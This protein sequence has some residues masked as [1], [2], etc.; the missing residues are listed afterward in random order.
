MFGVSRGA[1]S[2]AEITM[3]KP[4][5]RRGQC[6]Y[7]A[8]LVTML[9]AISV[10]ATSANAGTGDDFPSVD[11]LGVSDSEIRVGGVANV[12]QNPT[13]ISFGSAFDGVEAYFAYINQ[14]EGGV[15]G[16]KLVLSSKR[17][18][19]LANNRQ[20]VQGLLSQDDVFAALPMATALFTGAELL[21]EEGIPV[22]GWNIQE[23][24]GSENKRPGP[25]NF[26]A[27]DGAYRCYTCAQPGYT[28][29]MAKRL[30]LKNVAVLAYN[31]PQSASCAEGF[32]KSFEKYPT[33]KVA[34]ED[35]SLTFGNPDFSAPVS[36]MVEADVQLVLP[37]ID[38]NAAIIL[39]KE[40]LKQGLDAP[41]VLPNSYNY[42]AVE[43]NADIL[44]G[45]YVLTLFAPLETRPKPQGIKLYERWM[46]RTKGT[47]AENSI[48]GWINA[49][50]FVEGLK[51]AGPEFTRQKV[52]D[53]INQ[54]TSYTAKG[55]VPPIDWTAAHDSDSDCY[56]LSR[57]VDGK[58]KPAFGEPGK[59]FICFPDDLKVIP[60]NPL[61][62]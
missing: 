49:D 18:D 9:L 62:K 48:V 15:Y 54:M 26:F 16:R 11:Q 31:V 61:V 50:L 27:M 32:T 25:P 57:I 22:F 17:D 46:K 47:V 7:V 45:S 30:D 60:K 36:Q 53:A 33:G 13:G 38:F 10:T 51:A 8:L 24:W 37:C 14:T 19:Q 58:F 5:R 39:K 3:I 12:T 41:V 4:M 56:A 35:Q 23:E 42:G 34:F 52:I 59:P 40:M 43:D 1:V 28:Q 2:T 21:E 55:F 44:E 29:F 20:E 6:V